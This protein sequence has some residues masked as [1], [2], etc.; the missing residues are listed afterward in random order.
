MGKLSLKIVTPEG[1][2]EPIACDSVRLTICDNTEGKGGGSCGIRPG[3][4]NALL[5]LEKGPLAAFLAGEQI[6][7]AAC[8]NGFATVDHD[9]V[10]VVV[11]SCE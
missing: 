10:T 3:H 5:G 9:V 6:F 4:E 2:R 1:A 7:S 11:E 8:G